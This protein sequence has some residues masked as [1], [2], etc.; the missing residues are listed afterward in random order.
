MIG[1]CNVAWVF[2]R[3]ALLTLMIRILAAFVDVTVSKIPGTALGLGRAWRY[4]M[5]SE[6]IIHASAVGE[7]PQGEKK[8][9]IDSNGMQLIC[10]IAGAWASH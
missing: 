8:K 1:S 4:S 9:I 5:N 3:C 2:Y 7:G 6:P 10:E